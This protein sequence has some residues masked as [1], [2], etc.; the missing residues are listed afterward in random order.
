M[1]NYRRCTVDSYPTSSCNVNPVCEWGFSV[2]CAV[3]YVDK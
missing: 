1:L 3:L 2:E